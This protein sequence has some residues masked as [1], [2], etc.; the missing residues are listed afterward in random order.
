MIAL[1]TACLFFCNPCA[2]TELHQQK[3]AWKLCLATLMFSLVFLMLRFAC[4]SICLQGDSPRTSQLFFA[5]KTKVY[6]PS[7]S[8]SICLRWSQFTYTKWLL[9]NTNTYLKI[10]KWVYNSYSNVFGRVFHS[11]RRCSY[12][13]G[14]VSTKELIN[15]KIILTFYRR[16]RSLKWYWDQS[17]W[18]N[19]AW[20]M[21]KNAKRFEWKTRQNFLQL[22]LAST[23]WKLCHNDAFSD[24]FELIAIS[25]EGQSLQ[26]RDK[27]RRKT[28]VQNNLKNGKV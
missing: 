4:K 16:E 7:Q 12:A 28:K 14:S 17:D 6:S 2:C 22:Q 1:L 23:W 3:H 18:L 20:N 27:K 13:E 5:Y 26:Q 8:L 11:T 25:V 24:I 9:L 19:G 15:L 21:N 10:G